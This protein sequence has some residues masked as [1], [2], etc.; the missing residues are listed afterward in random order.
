MVMRKGQRRNQLKIDF[1]YFFFMDSVSDIDIVEL[2]KLKGNVYV[3]AGNV[4]VVSRRL[5]NFLQIWQLVSVEHT[6]ETTIH[7]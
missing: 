6:E 4:K 3:V 7:I 1:F 5:C 2:R